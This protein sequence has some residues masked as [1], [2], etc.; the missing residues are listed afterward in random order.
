MLPTKYTVIW[1]T[2][3]QDAAGSMPLGNGATGIN[4]WVEPSGDI[5]FYISR[6]D[7][8]GEFGQLYKVG[9]VRVRLFDASAQP[10]LQ[11]EAFRWELKLED[12]AALVRTERGWVRIWVDAHQPAVQVLAEGDAPL[13]GTVAFEMW[14]TEDRE[15][16]DAKERHG[17][18]VSAPYPVY[19]RK[20]EKVD[21]G[22]ARIGWLHHN[23]YSSWTRNL[24]QQGLSELVETETDPLLNRCFGA[25]IRGPGLTK[26]SQTELET[27]APLK[28]I[29]VSIV[30]HC[31]QV[32]DVQDWTV[33]IQKRAESVPAAS[34]ESGWTQHVDW[35]R[36]FWAR[37]W[38]DA[39]GCEAARK[40]SRGY[41]LQRYLNACSGRGAFPIKFNGSI[42]TVDW[43][44]D[45]ERFDADYRRWGPGYWHQNTRL[46]YWSMLY[47]GDFEMMRPYFEMYRKA[48]P[49]ATERIRKFCEHEGA[50][51]TET[52]HFWGTYL[53]HN[54][55]WLESDAPHAPEHLRR[56]P[57]LAAHL[58]QNPYIRLHNSS[59]LEVVYH[60]LLFY[61]Y[62]GDEAFLSETLL[63]I[64]EAVLDYYDQH[65]ERKDGKLHIT[66]AQVIEQ[67]WSAVNPMPELAGLRACLNELLELPDAHCPRRADWERLRSELPE[68]PVGEA[69]G[70]AVFTPAAEWDGPPH[71]SENPELY[72]VFPYHHCNLDSDDLDIG[73]ATFARRVYTHDMGWAQ[74]G[75]QAALL[76][77]KDEV[78]Q[79]VV[80]R[81]TTPSAY[82][83]FP[84]FW[85][86]GFD[87]IPDQ[88]QGGS[89]A[90]AFQLM[91][92]QCIGDRIHLLPAWPDDWSVD[93]KLAG[94]SG[95]R[96]SGRKAAGGKLSYQVEGGQLEEFK[97]LNDRKIN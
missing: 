79:S 80:N 83:R 47:S 20:D 53:E 94:P 87:W 16:V 84:A 82:A 23:A 28:R 62:A 91:V 19:H 45:G 26:K 40:V 35:W 44:Y 33:E 54:Y 15:V 85:G 51:F 52:M 90:H 67:W 65:F 95:L 18:H 5:C 96:V 88:D 93:F 89:A 61:R 13:T 78:R 7:T 31:E 92:M 29:E 30:T 66:P 81:L 34:D 25:L 12:G 75:M 9:K 64:A 55:G 42:F 86:P 50:A 21:F 59:G 77:L 32:D 6:T 63:P 38:I 69:D 27:I 8:W 10:L 11:G 76:G 17:L 68:L 70:E 56:D 60:G 43:N 37:S 39:D 3:S 73:R 24:Q 36:A 57:E 2:P 74:D 22:A 4:L 14:R 49:V 71:N 48:L 72:A 41:A 97:I 46:P 58:S 1:S